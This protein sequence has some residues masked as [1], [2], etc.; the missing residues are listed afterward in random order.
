MDKFLDQAEPTAQETNIPERDSISKEFQWHLD[1]IYIDDSAW[2]KDIQAVKNFL[3]TMSSYQGRLAE[4]AETLWAALDIRDKLD[5]TT[6][7]LFGYARMH[8]DE[9]TANTKYQ[10][11][12]SKIQSLLAETAASYAFIDPEILSL[13]AELFKGLLASEPRLKDYQFYFTNL[14]RQKSHILSPKEESLLS[15]ISEITQA[16]EETFQMLARADM[17][18]P[19]ITD[20]KGQLTP[21]SE[22][23]YRSFIISPSRQLRQQ[24]FEKLLGT[25]HQYR[26]TFA[27]T[28]NG[29]I[30]QDIFYAKTRNYPSRIEAALDADNVPSTVYDNLITTVEQHLPI[31]HRYVALKQQALKLPE[32]H[33]YDLYTPLVSEAKFDIAYDD[34]VKLVIDA[35]APLGE[36]YLTNLKSGLSSGWVDIYENKGKQT[37]AY[38]WGVY[39]VHPFVLLNYNNRYDDVST[40]AH[41]MGHA[42]H[43][44][45]SHKAQPY[46]TSAYTI[47]CAEVASTTNEILLMDHMLKI[48]EDPQQ[49]LYLINQY[50]ETVR[51][52]VFRQ[53][54]F[55]EFEKAIYARAEASESVTA[56]ELDNLWHN[57]N[58]KYYGQAMVVDA[59]IDVEW[60]RIPHFYRSFYVYKYATGYSAATTLA[61][62]IQSKGTRAQQRYI[63]F[64]QSGGSDYP[65]EILTTAGVNMSRPEPVAATLEKFSA[66][67]DQL[68]SGL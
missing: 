22:G 13:P 44:Y 33:M 53:T 30:K 7:K 24:A 37:G 17:K 62:Q 51:G 36:E 50:L 12:T 60:A 47:F 52:T 65:L 21:L 23:R 11:M 55:A 5:Q 29:N 32:I 42:M 1:D 59:E 48:T 3:P 25:Y 28:L 9:N 4:S 34:G 54:M 39:G 68:E 40:L 31:L 45:Y 20:E 56:D 8:R 16:S 67:L 14:L 35:L 38:S 19:S 18:F 58:V 66:L 64:L 49:R 43:S 46:I 6:N 2:E 57:L 10:A 63:K 27:S 15:Q 26:N 41:E 61:K